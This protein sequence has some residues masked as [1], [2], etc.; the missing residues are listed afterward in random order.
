MVHSLCFIVLKLNVLYDPPPRIFAYAVTET[1]WQLCDC[2]LERYI[3]A[4]A[5]ILY[6][7]IALIS[8]VTQKLA[9][10]FES[11]VYKRHLDIR[12]HTHAWHHY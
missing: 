6:V 10:Y 7:I 8:Q 3:I 5:I 4:I 12:P 2:C 1:V 9:T 11:S